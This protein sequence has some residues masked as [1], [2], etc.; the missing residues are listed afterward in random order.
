MG[1]GCSGH[2]QI[3]LHRI[4]NISRVGYYGINGGKYSQVN[5]CLVS[6]SIF[7]ILNMTKYADTYR[8]YQRNRGWQPDF[9]NHQGR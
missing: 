3:S 4:K 8:H 5:G 2:F 1:Y 7:R 6:D 9:F